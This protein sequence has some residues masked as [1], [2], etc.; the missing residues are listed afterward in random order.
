MNILI[1]IILLS[2]VTGI[3]G[4]PTTTLEKTHEGTPAYEAGIRGGDEIIA[5]NS[6]NVD[7][8]QDILA[9]INKQEAGTQFDITV[10]RDNQRL[11][12]PVT[13]KFDEQQKRYLVGIESKLNHNPLMALKNG[14]TMTWEM[15]GAIFDALKQLFSSKD[16][17]Q[18][19]SGPVGIVNMVSDTNTYGVLYFI[20]LVALI[21]VNVALFNLL[22]L[23]ALDGGRILFVF[24]RLI[25]GKTIT[26]EMEG[27]VHAI[28]MALLLGLFVFVTWNDIVRL[29]K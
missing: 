14:I 23:P 28:G 18:N 13:P 21:S 17:V 8:W 15:I 3:I 11:D 4:V 24:I 20:Y 5:V 7:N 22:P 9:E 25:T 1:A 6:Q 16:F 19:V 2:I 27:K 10:L 29:L 26:D 12:Y